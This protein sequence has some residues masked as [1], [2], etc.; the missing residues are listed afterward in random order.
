M[1]KR[2]TILGASKDRAFIDG[3]NYNPIHVGHH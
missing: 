1:S 2:F 3:W